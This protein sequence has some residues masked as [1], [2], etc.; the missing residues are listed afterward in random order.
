MLTTGGPIHRGPQ[1]TLSFN[2]LA[3]LY[4]PVVIIMLSFVQFRECPVGFPGTAWYL[5]MLTL[6]SALFFLDRPM[7]TRWGLRDGRG[8]R[9]ALLTPRSSDLP[10]GLLLLYSR[11]RPRNL[12]PLGLSQGLLREPCTSIT[13]VPLPL[14][15]PTAPT[16]SAIRSPPQSSTCPPSVTSSAISFLRSVTTTSL[17]RW[18]P[19]SL[20]WQSGY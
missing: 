7:L 19:S 6:A 1:T 15:D 8:S 20:Q 11:R 13:T 2:D 16:C 4:C 14:R 5:V 17:L 12:S 18:E 9:R 10:A 3:L